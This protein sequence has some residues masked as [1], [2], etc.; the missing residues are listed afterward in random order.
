MAITKLFISKYKN[1]EN[2]DIDLT[3]S[4]TPLIIGQNGSGKSNL[5]EAI[6][7]ILKTLYTFN[8]EQCDFNFLISI[9]SRN[10][11][12][13][14]FKKNNN[15]IIL[16]DENKNYQKMLFRNRDKNKYIDVVFQYRYLPNNI[17]VYYLGDNKRLYSIAKSIEKSNKSVNVVDKYNYSN[18]SIILIENEIQLAALIASYLKGLQINDV[19]LIVSVVL[20]I[21]KSKKELFFNSI[22]SKYIK[23]YQENKYSRDKIELESNNILEFSLIKLT[24]TIID[25]IK[26]DVFSNFN[27]TNQYGV[28][29][30]IKS[31][32]SN[33]NSIQLNF[34]ELSEGQQ[35]WAIMRSFAYVFNGRNDNSIFLLDEPDAFFNPKW[36][37]ELVSSIR[38]LT[39]NQ[40][41]LS[42]HSSNILSRANNEDIYYFEQGKMKKLRTPVYGRDIRFIQQFIQDIPRFPSEVQKLVDSLFDYIDNRQLN[43]ASKILNELEVI[44]GNDDP[45]YTEL[46]TILEFVKGDDL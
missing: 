38:K 39:D 21:K 3:N 40:I 45:Y 19:F 33:Q 4:F 37:N 36:Q 44:F 20:Y 5:L 16:M 17:I 6:L 11:L 22:L 9:K 43:Q 18:N 2:I 25:L 30:I 34:R 27:E 29:I 32:D 14:T 46:R 8:L 10:Q 41:F 35:N 1:L 23:P 15:D 31:Y 7:I 26:S 24:N 12:E 13:I 42:S 28:N